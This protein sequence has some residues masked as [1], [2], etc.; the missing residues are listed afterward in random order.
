MPLW[1]DAATLEDLV[2]WKRER[3]NDRARPGDPFICC[4]WSS[5]FG[6][7]ETITELGIEVLKSVS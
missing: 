3:E 6:R 1:W 7:G 2:A 4:L 5:R